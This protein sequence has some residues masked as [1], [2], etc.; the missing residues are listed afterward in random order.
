MKR[1]KKSRIFIFIVLISFGIISCQA[2]L[3]KT[4]SPPQGLAEPP[5]L[6]DYWMNERRIANDNIFYAGAASVDISPYDYRVWIGG[7][8]PG[9]ISKG[10]RDPI[11]AHALVLH[12]GQHMLVFCWLDLIGLN[13]PDVNIIRRLSSDLNQQSIIIGSTHNHQSPDT[14]G[15]WGCGFLIPGSSGVLPEYQDYMRKRAA[16]AISDAVNNARPAK[17]RYGESRIP[18]G[19]TQNLWFPGDESAKDN[20]ISAAAVDD[21]NGKRIATL[22]N[23]ACHAESLYQWNNYVSADWPGRLYKHLENDSGGV[24]LFISKAGGGMVVP[25]VSRFD[26][27]KYYPLSRRIQWADQ[28]GKTLS[29]LTIKALESAVPESNPQIRHLQKDIYIPLENHIFE[30]LATI[31][32]FNWKERDMKGKAIRAEVHAFTIGKG[33]FVTAPGE[34]FPIIGN[35]LSNAMPQGPRFVLTLATDELGYMM[36]ENQWS[37]KTYS[38]ERTAS[39]GSKAGP[40]VLEA[41]KRL[42]ESLQKGGNA[43]E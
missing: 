28:F 25:F 26:Q 11:Y 19:W 10:V 8:G 42:I 37:D 22:V 13:L 38:Y 3:L 27:R 34:L 17:I 7:F 5:K 33:Y 6:L 15:M 23:L 32:I 30:A 18:P 4:G 24:T 43:I 14:I 41:G 9:R 40:M 12:D 1:I 36:T 21:L 29:E 20:T 35:E 2:G 39:L 16:M 31:G